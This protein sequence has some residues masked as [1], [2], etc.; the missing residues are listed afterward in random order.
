AV[1]IEVEEAGARAPLPGAAGDAGRRRDVRE[2]AVPVVLVKKV[3]AGCGHV[4]IEIAVV[5]VVS[6]RD[7]GL[8]A[9]F[10]GYTSLLRHIREGPILVVVIEGIRAA[11]RAVDEIE[12]G[13]AV[14][15]V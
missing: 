10:A 1:A 14:V 6:D 15:V 4:E 7:A 13:E 5:V 12:V 8:V 3:G 2:G 9:P 11:G